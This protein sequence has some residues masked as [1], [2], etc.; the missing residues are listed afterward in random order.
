MEDMVFPFP[1]ANGNFGA[2]VWGCDKLNVTIGQNDLWDHRICH[3]TK[4]NSF[5]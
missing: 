1:L 2:L 3:H 5:F 4:Q